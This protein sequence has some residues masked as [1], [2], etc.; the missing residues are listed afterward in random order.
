MWQPFPARLFFLPPSTYRYSHRSLPL[1]DPGRF[2]IV[3]F[4]R[5]QKLSTIHDPDTNRCTKLIT[6]QPSLPPSVSSL[7]QPTCKHRER[8]RSILNHIFVQRFGSDWIRKLDCLLNKKRT[9]MGFLWGE[10]LRM[11]LLFYLGFVVFTQNRLFLAWILGCWSTVQKG[12]KC[13]LLHFS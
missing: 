8:R 3:L 11:F 7:L 6:I 1:D 10:M 12:K 5:N 13:R 2:Q 9:G 4:Q